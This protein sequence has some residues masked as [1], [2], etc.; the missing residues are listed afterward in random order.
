MNQFS[1]IFDDNNRGRYREK[2][3]TSIPGRAKARDVGLS[4]WDYDSSRSFDDLQL[5]LTEN[6]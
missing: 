1:A 5:D 2:E 3:K 4:H 6:K